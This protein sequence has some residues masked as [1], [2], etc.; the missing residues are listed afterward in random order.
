MVP[1]FPTLA[2]Q[3]HKDQNDVYSFE[4]MPEV[5]V[6]K[7]I[8]WRDEEMTDADLH[9]VRQALVSTQFETVD[10][11]PAWRL[12]VSPTSGGSHV[13]LFFH[14]SMQD[15]TSAGA[16]LFAI[17]DALNLPVDNPTSLIKIPET[18]EIPQSVEHYME[19]PVTEKGKAEFIADLSKPSDLDLWNGGTILDTTD[20]SPFTQAVLRTTS[21]Q[22]MKT[23]LAEC[24]KNET[25]VTCFLV[26]VMLYA[27]DLVLGDDAHTKLLATVP[28]NLRDIVAKSATIKPSE[29]VL[30]GDFVNATLVPYARVSRDNKS[31]SL[32]HLWSVA[33]STR[34]LIQEKALNITTS[35]A[36][37]GIAFIP[38]L[39]CTVL[40]NQKK[41]RTSGAPRFNS[42]E[43]SSLVLPGAPPSPTSDQWVFENPVFIQGNEENSAMSLSAIGY[44]GGDQIMSFT[45]ASESLNDSI[46]IGV[47]DT[48]KEL[49][50]KVVA[51]AS[52]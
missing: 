4:L 12:M 27:I 5:D 32:D 47:A 45:W 43:V 9:R 19:L 31:V 14:H 13:S 8:I 51:K 18:T 40:E 15:G 37:L 35:T 33:R 28:Q 11:I 41:L 3:I 39:G 22:E 2:L 52:K 29:K 49:I 23:L 20:F 34:Q 17:R 10:Q 50:A 21:A 48:V 25:T 38:Y 16:V 42:C 26:A 24:R 46:A 44:R 6:E 7:N 30:M 36:D 1:E